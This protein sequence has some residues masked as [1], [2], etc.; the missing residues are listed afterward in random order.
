[1]LTKARETYYRFPKNFWVLMGSTL[2][3]QIGSW[4]LFPFFALYITDHFDVGMTEVGI[5]MAIFA[6][7]NL[8]GGF[9]GGAMTD[10]YGRKTM[11]LFGLVVSALS[12]VTMAFVNDLQLFYLTAAIVGIVGSSGGPA[13]QAM[14][15]DI[16]PED[17]RIEGYGIS[18]IVMNL[19]VTIG[20]IIGGFLASYSFLLLFIVDAVTSLITAAIAAINLPETKPEASPDKESQSL[21]DTFKGYS[22]VIKDKPFIAFVFAF[23][24][25]NIVY[26][27]MNST[28]SVFLRDFHGI[29]PQGFGYILSLNAVIVVLFQLSVARKVADKPPMLVIAFGIIFYMIG[30]GMY[31]FVS[32]FSL[33]AVG[34]VI[35]TIGEI[36]VSPVAQ[37]IVVQF[38]PED[39]RGRYMGAFGLAW[40]VPMAI[41][42]FAAGVIMDN[43]DAN[44]VWYG[45][46]ILSAVAMLGFMLLHTS[47][48]KRLSVTQE[49]T[50]AAIN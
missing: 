12:S 29:S 41:G 34:M 11:L 23:I 5:L 45:G 27:Q 10:K 26:M 37:T 7:T 1:M 22:T 36:I 33:F 15:A 42:P 32:T 8:F 49:A 44:W 39:M 50:P 47:V 4:M 16:L 43:Y 35:I 18:R 14:I 30:F 20:P 21:L 40:M 2:I 6:L 3:D 46:A 13:Q 38:S 25:M 19:A 31:G 9:I 17:K 24:L 48:N 28:M